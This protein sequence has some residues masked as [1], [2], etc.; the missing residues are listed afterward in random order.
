MSD[1]SG[2]GEFFCHACT[3]PGNVEELRRK[4][5]ALS[6]F[7]RLTLKQ[8]RRALDKVLPQ[9][10]YEKLAAMVAEPRPTEPSVP[11]DELVR[12]RESAA[13]SVRADCPFCGDARPALLEWEHDTFQPEDPLWH[14]ECRGCGAHGPVTSGAEDAAAKWNG[15]RPQHLS[16]VFRIVE[17]ATRGDKEKVRNYA[18]LL[19]DKLEADGEA[20]SAKWLRQ[21]A[22]GNA[23][24]CI[25]AHQS[26]S[27][28]AR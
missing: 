14:A 15:A 23:G 12:Q 26:D 1:I 27:T 13:P 17:G 7:E 10:D 16:E 21:I 4:Y 3:L 28:A 11:L 9:V 2:L 25:I 18:H 19:A 8:V 5:F 6:K 24:A 20:N 22:D